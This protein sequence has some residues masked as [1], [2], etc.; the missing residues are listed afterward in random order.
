MQFTFDHSK[1]NFFE[2]IGVTEEQVSDTI[3]KMIPSNG[4]GSIMLENILKF[5]KEEIAFLAVR[6]L[7]QMTK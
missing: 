2:A 6:V 5:S 7:L 4:I 3:N 1:E